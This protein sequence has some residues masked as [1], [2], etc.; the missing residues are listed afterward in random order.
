MHSTIIFNKYSSESDCHE[1]TVE[2]KTKNLFSE[3]GTNMPNNIAFE[4]NEDDEQGLQDKRGEIMISNK[5]ITSL[6][7][8]GATTFV[9]HVEYVDQKV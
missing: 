5:I 3:S 8:L 6:K 2:E 9:D 4:T 1:P 7:D